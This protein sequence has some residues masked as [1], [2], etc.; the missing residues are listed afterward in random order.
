MKKRVLTSIMAMV[1]VISL[2]VPAFGATYS[3]LK[4]H[5][6]KTYMEALADSGYMTGYS[7]GTMKPDK[8]IT[9]AEALALFSRL[10]SLTDLQSNLIDAD[11]GS[12]AKADVPT[13]LSWAYKNVEICLAAGIITESELKSVDLSAAI[14]KEQL[15]V[16]LV[17]AVQLTSQ[18]NALSGVSLSFTDAA[19]ISSD[20]VGSIAELVT[21]GIVKGDEKNN[22]L[23]KS[24]VTR[25]V[26]ATM[27][28]R[29]LDYLKTKGTTLSISNYVGLSQNVGIIRSVSGSTFEL[30]GY[31]GLTRVY[32][33]A[34]AGKVTVNDAT[35]SLSSTYINSKATITSK[36][37]AVTNIA[38]E[39]TSSVDWVQGAVTS[40]S[41]STSSG[42]ITVTKQDLTVNSYNVPST[43]KI[44]RE[45]AT[46][47]FTSVVKS[48]SVTLKIVGGNVSEL[49]AVS[50]DKTLAAKVNEVTYG[51]TVSLKLED[52]DGTLY[53]FQFAISSL[54]TIKR[55]DATVT[56][57]RVKVGGSLTLT[58]DD[59]KVTK[60]VIEGSENSI[61]GVVTSITTST[62]GTAWVISTTNGTTTSYTLDENVTA[63]S[64][65]TEI[66]ISKVAVGD[67][68]S[69][70][71]YE[72]VITEVKLVSSASTTTKVTGTVL[73]V[74]S[75]TGIVTIL[76]ADKKLIYVNVK[77]TSSII[78]AKTGSSM[79]YTGIAVGS[80]LV[81]YGEYTDSRNFTAKS[82]IIE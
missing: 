29:T 79:Y 55:G 25:A 67:T 37:G 48:D 15:S 44:T 80:S 42:T 4:N 39:S 66:N 77:S 78:N 51:T 10:Y 35:G 46:V 33:L 71:A 31:D 5:W 40:V 61:N 41:S 17:R 54:P 47:A 7:D 75:S 69:I 26:V 32:T 21:I 45:G 34:S 50:G 1:L 73:D 56:I 49:Y 12:V 82:I 9:Y 13:T 24:S 59:C 65:T 64:G 70:V 2:A 57:D 53:S 8:N 68:V 3:D 58:I 52:S 11:Y 14:S 76:T 22:F 36:N 60:I 20:S 81:A 72:D 16:Y 63:Y 38:I 74:N 30:C 27:V 6:A 62:G 43:A 18:A 28:Y 23:P 19:S